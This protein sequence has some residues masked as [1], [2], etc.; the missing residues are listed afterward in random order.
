VSASLE[1]RIDPARLRGAVAVLMGGDS[2]ER[3]VS[4]RGGRA[5]HQALE[6]RVPGALAIDVDGEILARLQQERVGHAFL[7]LHG[8]GGED[9]T[10][11]GALEQLQI[12]YTGS[13]VLA[14]AL[15]MD[16][17][18]CKWLW[19]GLGIDTPAFALLDGAGRYPE[20]EP[21]LGPQMIVKPSREGSS[22]GM[23]RVSGADELDAAYALA[24]RYD[25]DVLVET[26]IDG[27]EYTVA[28]L[29]DEA[30]PPIRL[31]TDRGFYDYDAKYVA[32]DTRYICPCGLGADEEQT[33]RTLALRAYRSLDCRGWGR[34]DLM[35]DRSGRWL[36]LE[37]N[38]CPGMTD[39]SLVPM[40]AAAAGID[41]EELVARIF[42]LSLDT[43][44]GR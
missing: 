41:F 25:D 28:I 17:L 30:L 19:A 42:T 7:M 31:E 40:A 11:Q 26:W 9:G 14:S 44:G 6:A 32:D 24:C 33:L 2:A 27:A 22:I 10:I 39:H 16:K 15:A 35:R 34:V 3:E 18:R 5:V 23:M 8:R 1:T 37:V 38:T 4:L 43:G 29:G 21:L 20:L 12:A 36:V 13:G